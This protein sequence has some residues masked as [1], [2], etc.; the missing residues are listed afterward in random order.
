MLA[1]IDVGSNTVRLLLGEVVA[2]R[3]EPFLYERR[4]TRLKGGQTA[5]GHLADAAMQ[6]TAQ[7]LQEFVSLLRAHTPRSCRAVGTAALR[8]APNAARFLRQVQEDLG[9][10]IDIASGDEEARLSAS[11]VLAA[12]SPRPAASLIVDI[13]GGSTEFILLKHDV[14]Q[15]Q[16]SIPLGVVALAESGL[17]ETAIA[18]L[19]AGQVDSVFSSLSQYHSPSSI[20]LSLVGTAGTATTLA[21]MHLCMTRY[22]WRRVN[23]CRLPA[24]ELE[25]MRCQLSA[26]PV[27]QR[28]ALPGM[29][30]GRGDLILHGIA[31]FQAI[32]RRLEVSEMT[33]S[34]FG[35]LEGVLLDLSAKQAVAEN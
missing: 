34:D 32:M 35:L 15:F 21:A 7:A 14:V 2:G 31:I 10:S 4:I 20:P 18:D 6:R 9:L 13:G 26:L 16:V 25:R 28:E 24:S 8:Q 5:H 22:D 33:I 12:L 29:E 19:I 11:G 27:D 17:S 3:V 1:A 23:N 30:A